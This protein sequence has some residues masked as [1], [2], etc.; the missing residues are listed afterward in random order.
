MSVNEATAA[1]LNTARQKGGRIVAVGTTAVRT[2]ESICDETGK[3][4]PGTGETSLFIYPGYAFKAVDALIT[5]FHLPDSTPLLLA[6]AFHAYKQCSLSR[7]KAERLRAKAWMCPHPGLHPTQGRE[8]EFK[9][10]NPF[11]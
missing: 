10:I 6:N 8:K 2:L 9:S 7:C 4:H 1:A 11:I 3:F 5:N